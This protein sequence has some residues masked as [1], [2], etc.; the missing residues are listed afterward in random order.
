[1][2]VIL[3]ISKAI[4]HEQFLLTLGFFLFIFLF[5]FYRPLSR[6]SIQQE[7]Y[8]KGALKKT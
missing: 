2:C 3:Y 7:Q 1:M 4:L 8:S 5:I 6:S